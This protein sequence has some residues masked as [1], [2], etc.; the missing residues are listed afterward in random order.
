MWGMCSRSA[1]FLHLKRSCLSHQTPSTC[2]NSFNYCIRVYFRLWSIVLEHKPGTSQEIPWVEIDKDHKAILWFFLLDLTLS[3]PSFE[4]DFH[5]IFSR[6]KEFWH[7]QTEATHIRQ[8]THISYPRKRWSA[9]WMWL[10]FLTLPVEVV[11]MESKYSRCLEL[12]S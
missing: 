11:W 3:K 8:I 6:S 7:I 5:K 10:I 2:Y 9:I 12:V 4:T 1:N